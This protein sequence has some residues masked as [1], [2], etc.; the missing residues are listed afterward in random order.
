MKRQRG[1]VALAAIG[2]MFVTGALALAGPEAKRTTT[3]AVFGDLPYTQEQIHNFDNLPAAINADPKVSR[4]IHLGDIKNGSTPCEDATYLRVKSTFDKFQDPLVFTPGDNEWTDCHRTNNGA[5]LPT[6]RLAFERSIFFAKPGWT[7]GIDR[8]KVETQK[9]K[10]G[11]AFPEHVRWEQGDVTFATF[12]I[13]GSNNDLVPWGAPWD[14]AAYQA[15]QADEVATRT[16]AVLRWIDGTFAEAK[17][18][19]ARGVVLGMQADM[20]DPAAPLSA[21]TGYTEIVQSIAAHSRAFRKPVLLMNG[22]SHHFGVDHPLADPTTGF[23]QQYGI[24]TPVPNLTRLTVQGST[25]TPSSW[26]RLTIDPSDPQL[27]SFEEVPVAF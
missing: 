5:Y 25:S 4:A 3:I 12:N 16:G 20:W 1:L 22:D 15:I 7:L 9:S 10:N 21:Y 19:H 27:F 6:E 11:Q 14:T 17:D 23:N 24:T 2:A 18:E 8:R 13:P 26:V